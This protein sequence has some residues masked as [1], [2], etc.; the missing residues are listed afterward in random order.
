MIGL[1]EAQKL[2]IPEEE[3]YASDCLRQLIRKAINPECAGTCSQLPIQ[4]G[5]RVLIKPNWVSH[6]R[7]HSIDRSCLHTSQEFVLAALEETIA[8]QPSTLVIGD[9]PIQSCVWEQLISQSFREKVSNLDPDRKVSIIDFRRTIMRG[10][11]LKAKQEAELR[12]DDRFTLFDLREDSMLEPISNPPGKFRVTMYDPV[13]MGRRHSPGRHQY[14]IAREALEADV[15][16]NLPKLKTHRKAGITGAL[17][18]LVGLNGNK[19]FLPHHRKGGS[20]SGGDC[21]PGRSGLKS[22]AEFMLDMAN[23]RIGKP[24]YCLWMTG[25]RMAM[26][27]R[28]RFSGECEIDGGWSGNDTVWRTVLDLNRIAVYGRPDGT[29]AETPQRTILNLTDALICGQGNGPLAPTPFPLGCVTFS[30]SSVDADRLHCA[31]FGFDPNQIPMVREA[32]N[33]FRWPLPQTEDPDILR[34]LMPIAPRKKA[35][36]APGWECLRKCQ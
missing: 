6:I 13:L 17:K 11:G 4:P 9:A 12:L 27:A 21:Y 35:E 7:Q 15:I 20:A 28:I 24:S 32:G 34:R 23:G 30:D 22:F 36:P 1:A 10:S 33:G 3:W 29:M 25:A 5:T 31:L 16:L 8:C 26:K 19:E 18:N 14:L 2:G